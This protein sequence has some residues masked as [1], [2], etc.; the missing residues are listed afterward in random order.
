MM[1]KTVMTRQTVIFDT[2]G[3]NRLALAQDS[4][5][6]TRGLEIGFDVILNA[7]NVDEI[8]ATRDSQ[9]RALL[10]SYFRRLASWSKII[11]PAH[12]ILRR[13]IHAHM[14][15]PSR[16]DWMHV[17]VRESAYED[18]I[19]RYSFDDDLAEVQKIRQRKAA[20]EWKHI[21]ERLRPELDAI[22]DKEPGKR[23]NNYREAVARASLLS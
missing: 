22:L 13:I 23:P 14:E 6:L 17:D 11:S 21:W 10:L 5:A 20:K 4:E 19:N 18:A 2:S 7:M 16:F 1:K 8:I 12:E 3:I 15:D 9:K